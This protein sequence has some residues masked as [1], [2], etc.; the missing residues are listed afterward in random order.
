AAVPWD[1][2]TRLAEAAAMAQ[3]PVDRLA[4]HLERLLGQQRLGRLPDRELLA[5]FVRTRDEAAFAA[6]VERHG[7][8]V[9]RVCRR[10][11]RD[12]HAAEAAFQATF[13]VFLRKAASVRRGEL[14]ANWL[15]GVAHRLAVHARASAAARQDRERRLAPRQA[16]DVLH[17]VTACECSA[18]LDE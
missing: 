7:P 13:L 6:L 17:E 18:L 14:L 2:R 15:Y 12:P 4:R 9:L 1:A 3:V 10:T 11:L 8:M 5:R 16:P